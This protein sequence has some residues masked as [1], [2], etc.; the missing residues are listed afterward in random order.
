MVSDLLPKFLPELSRLG[1]NAGLKLFC[2]HNWESFLV[3]TSHT[4][5]A[6][7]A[8]PGGVVWRDSGVSDRSLTDG[9]SMDKSQFCPR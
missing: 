9:T 8:Q 5:T 1:P 6:S 3:Q 7:H 2:A 4:I